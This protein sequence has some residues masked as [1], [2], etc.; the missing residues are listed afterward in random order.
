MSEAGNK[1]NEIILN[2]FLVSA[3]LV[4]IALIASKHITIGDRW[5]FPYPYTRKIGIY[6]F[7]IAC[8]LVPLLLLLVFLTEKY[9]DRYAGR[10]MAI[11][12]V[13]GTFSQVILSSL[14]IYPWQR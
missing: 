3:T 12:F 11:W 8:G 14:Y 6:P 1:R 7:L 10:L 13:A 2:V 5:T 4:L 9:L